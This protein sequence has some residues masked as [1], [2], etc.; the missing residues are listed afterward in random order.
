MILLVCNLGLA[1]IFVGDLFTH[2]LF[3]SYFVVFFLFYVGSLREVVFKN[4]GWLGY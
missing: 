4:G 1:I 3:I 2:Y